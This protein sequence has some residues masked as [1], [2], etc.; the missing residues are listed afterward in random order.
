MPKTVTLG[1]IQI[2]VSKNVPANIAKTEKFIRRAARQGAKIICLQ[3][4]YN[5]IY[6]PRQRKHDVAKFL[7]TV[8]GPSTRAFSALAKELGVVVIVPIFEQ[9]KNGKH[10][11][12]AVV[13]DEKG[14]LLPTYRKLH[15]PHDPGFYEKDYF[16][17]GDLGYRVYKTKF[18]TFAVLICFDQWFPEAA[19]IAKLKGAEI[20]FYPTAIGNIV[21]TIP[22]EGDWHEAWETIQRSHAIANS[23]VVAAVNRVGLEGEKGKGKT[24]FWGQ[25]FISDSFGK[26][27]V[28]G[29]KTKEEVVLGTVDLSR[30]K[31]IAEG[32]GFL[33][34]R[35]PA[36][37]G[38]L[39]G[40]KPKGK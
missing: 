15:I 20:I 40:N 2:A 13:I 33:R 27:M 3:E 36:T 5:A 7:E 25:S 30:N 4:L 32:W 21:G 11:N 22:E 6:F 35:R 28:R 19:R 23:V 17:E 24:R 1:L 31:P 29:S 9:G 10:Y 14:R 26:V 8:P 18:A 12:S 39:C 37:Y 38:P 34:N 16:E